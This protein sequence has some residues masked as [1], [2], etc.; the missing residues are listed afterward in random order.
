M[1]IKSPIEKE[2]SRGALHF[3]V[4]P[5]KKTAIITKPS[6]GLI[7]VEVKIRVPKTNNTPANMA[8]IV[9][10][11]IACIKRLKAPE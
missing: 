10:C 5:K 11:G 6:K 2:A 8:I 9:E 4:L 7:R 1:T 3:N